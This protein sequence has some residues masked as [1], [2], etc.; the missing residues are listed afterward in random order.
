M[1]N[2]KRELM[3]ASMIALFGA[4]SVALAC[5]L[6]FAWQL[7]DNRAATLNTMPVNNTFAYQVKT[8]APPPRNPLNVVESD[9]DLDATEAELLS[10]DQ[11]QVV[12]QMRAANSG[13]EAF[14]QGALLPA[15]IRI[16]T[17]GA[18]DYHKDANAKAIARFQAVLRLPA[19]DRGARATWAAYMLG[20]L[21]GREN[22]VK[23]ASE[24]FELT[25]K[26]AIEGVPDRLG[27]GVA[28]YGEEARLYL[29]R[30][31]S[32]VKAKKV[33]S[34]QWRE[35][36][37]D[38]ATAVALY[39]E[40][41]AQRSTSGVDSLRIVADEVLGNN[42][43]IEAS[44]CD[45]MVQQ[46]LVDRLLAGNAAPPEL[47]GDL[48]SSGNSPLSQVA[49]ASQK[50]G[51]HYTADADQLAAI[52]YRS[53]DYHL[54]QRLV[55]HATGP[56][57]LWVQA[58]LAM[59]Q[60]NIGE[61]A[62][63][64]AEASKAFPTSSGAD[65]ADAGIKALI[66]GQNSVLTLARG[67]YVD[68]LEQLYPYAG[69]FWGD[70]TH[71]AERVLTVDELKTFVD[72]HKDPQVQPVVSLANLPGPFGFEVVSDYGSSDALNQFWFGDGRSP[73]DHLRDLLAR[74]L[75]RAGRY[76]EA[77][78]YAPALNVKSSTAAAATPATSPTVSVPTA[79]AFAVL[80]PQT[81]HSP[82]DV[83]V[84]SS[85]AASATSSPAAAPSV[86][87]PTVRA[88]PLAPF[89]FP[90]QFGVSQTQA[91]SSPKS[92]VVTEPKRLKHWHGHLVLENISEPP[93][94]AIAEYVRA[95]DDANTSRTN[96][97]RARGWYRAA[98]LAGNFKSGNKIMGTEGP[99]DYY[100]QP[101][102]GGGSGQREFRADD[103]FVT[104]G[105]RQRFA[106]SASKPDFRYHYIFV[107]ADEAIRAADLL[108]RRSQAFAAVLCHA[109]SWM[110]DGESCPASA[111]SLRASPT[112]YGSGTANI[113]NPLTLDM[114][115]TE[116]TARTYL[117]CQLYQRY[118][119]EG[120]VVPLATDF[121]H[122]CPEPDF[123]SAASFTQTQASREARRR[124][125]MLRHRWVVVMQLA[126]IAVVLGVSTVWFLRHRYTAFW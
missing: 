59:Q 120:A 95:L 56:L 110:T 100:V 60:G 70:I 122:D 42:A 7:L 27:L 19:T 115:T 28:S 126:L 16:Y 119:K 112:A 20:R 93:E 111:S 74:R 53:G 2:L 37:R 8:L 123:V 105:E 75:V 72:T 43:A 14:E 81:Q 51:D 18:V 32:Y 125:L 26:L 69:T 99:Q 79:A 21:Y 30:A 35:Y 58:R 121:G 108:P 62:R 13:D 117:T 34:Q 57:A 109:T 15:A 33:S 45:P 91:Q 49:S 102:V 101:E 55:A 92:V 10:S 76:K 116:G 89:A 50:C 38:I 25:R 22:D 17:A 96:V 83:E 48:D 1:R 94:D 47:G 31:D 90:A 12:K 4:S 77:L 71:I 114:W 36:G 82:K 98:V 113:V 65:S 118:L 97:D 104:D 85:T 78:S 68:A 23:K 66:T 9:Y 46:L 61:A 64:Y 88:F 39:A 41:A 124:H 11:V 44:I 5:G 103:R 84:K 86:S 24:A 63:Y 52:A 3:A 106:A 6:E 40:Q 80:Q 87:A 67:E 29:N 73:A 107:G 54:A